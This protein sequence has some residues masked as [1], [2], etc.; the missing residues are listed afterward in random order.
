M[1][2]ISYGIAGNVMVVTGGSRGIGL[3]LAKLL[4]AQDARGGDLRSKAGGLGCGT[5]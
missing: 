3:D 1:T 4:L 5:R 2:D